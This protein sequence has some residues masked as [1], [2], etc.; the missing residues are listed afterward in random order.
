M[1]PADTQKHARARSPHHGP[2]VAR[3]QDAPA[4]RPVDQIPAQYTPADK[5]AG[6]RADPHP[7]ADD[8]HGDVTRAAAVGHDAGLGGLLGAQDRGLH[9]GVDVGD[10]GRELARAVTRAH[11]HDARAEHGAGQGGHHRGDD[12]RH[13]AQR[14]DGR[15]RG[16]GG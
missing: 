13:A 8:A 3:D 16:G 7:Q 2:Q 11:Q 6:R 14:R 1:Q 10:E 15:G 5:A 9:Q 12:R 4:D